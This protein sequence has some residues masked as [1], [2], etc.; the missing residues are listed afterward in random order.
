MF[1][2]F[3]MALSNFGIS[4]GTIFGAVLVDFLGIEDHDYSN[5]PWAVFLRSIGKLYT[6]LL[7]LGI[8]MTDI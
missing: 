6:V 7:F 2:A 8:I 3:L 4:V 5:M 1:F